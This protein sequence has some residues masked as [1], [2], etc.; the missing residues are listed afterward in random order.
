MRGGWCA[1]V[2][3][4][5]G[6]GVGRVA[7]R[8]FEGVV[9]ALCVCCLS[10]GPGSCVC[11]SRCC[12]VHHFFSCRFVPCSLR[13]LVQRRQSLLVPLRL[14]LVRCWADMQ[15]DSELAKP[16]TSARP[17][18]LKGWAFMI[19]WKTT[20]SSQNCIMHMSIATAESHSVGLAPTTNTMLRGLTGRRG[21]PKT[22][23]GW[24]RKETVTV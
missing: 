11:R 19:P 10:L 6:R 9:A 14:A 16:L 18:N 1:A 5:Y 4:C 8:C 20:T 2:L 23:H 21:A 12:V 17:L 24:G 22:R 7:M 15:A 13:G 3:V